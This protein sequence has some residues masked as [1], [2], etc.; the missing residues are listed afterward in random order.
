MLPTAPQRALHGHGSLQAI[1][2]NGV[3]IANDQ[4]QSTVTSQRLQG[5]ETAR[6]RLICT[7]CR[8]T[9]STV[10]HRST[11]RPVDGSASCS[12][13]TRKSASDDD[14]VEDDVLQ[15]LS[16]NRTVPQSASRRTPASTHAVEDDDI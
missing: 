7:T 15:L 2:V 9:P 8:A 4:K 13:P 6:G 11:I 1:F 10:L 14:A 12:E 3:E 16:R 5:I